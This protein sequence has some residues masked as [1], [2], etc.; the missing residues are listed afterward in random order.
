MEK[1]VFIRKTSGLVRPYGAADTTL[2]Y[3]LIIFS[4][5]NTT[6]QFPWFFGFN[7]GAD[8]VTSLALAMIPTG[9]LMVCYWAIASA[10][11]RSGSDY[12][13]FARITHPALG[14]A[15]SMIY[16]YML[17]LAGP[18]TVCFTYG[19]TI[20]ATLVAWGTLYN[21]PSL[22]ASGTWLSGTNGAFIFAV[23]L[24][25]IYMSFAILGHRVGKAL[26]YTSWVVQVFALFLM[27]YILGTTDT[28]TFSSNWN[29]LMSQYT[30]YQGVFDLAKGAGWVL[31]PITFGATASSITLSFMLMSGAA[32]GAGSISGEIR[33]VNR[34]IPVALLFSNLF[35]FVIWSLSGLTELHATGYSWLVA[36]SW[37]WDNVPSKFPLPLP[38]SMPLMLAIATYP[39]QMLT[40][41]MLSS[42]CLANMA[43]VY[44]LMMTISR[45]FFAWAFDRLLPTRMADVNPRFKTPH[46]AL[47]A[48]GIVMLVSAVLYSYTGFPNA[49]AAISTLMVLCYAVLACT[50]VVFPFTKWKTLLDQLPTF[51]RKRVG[52]PVVSWLGLLTAIILFWAAYAV[53]VNPL[54]TGTAAPLTAYLF[55]GIFVLGLIVYYV[56]KWYNNKQGI[57]VSLIFKEVPPT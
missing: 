28:A 5:L 24:I 32:Q 35:A 1:T 45:Y 4:I 18:L 42:F 11:P 51:M 37:L 23:V 34:S 6:I 49:F 43:F 54:L 31:A 53:T 8:L 46:W 7:P 55:G 39:N 48:T 36:L 20:S 10:M 38:P 16:W 9:M 47:I 13:W 21:A 14:S 30:T 57:D 50:V 44:I 19:Y 26:L 56:S 3:T 2:I 33:N 17:L 12:V 40:L 25:L 15:W 22:A 29:T 27:W 41:V 52:I